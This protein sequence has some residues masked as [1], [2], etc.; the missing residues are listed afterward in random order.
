MPGSSSASEGNKNK[1]T[2]SAHSGTTA[3]EV[4]IFFFCESLLRRDG[5]CN[6]WLSLVTSIGHRTILTMSFY[7][8]YFVV[9]VFTITVASRYD[10]TST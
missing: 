10:I 3:A 4:I 2:F 9:V 1:R 8:C 5:G 6:R 7:A